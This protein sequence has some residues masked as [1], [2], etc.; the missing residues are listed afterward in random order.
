MTDRVAVR[1]ALISLSNKT[2]LDSL[3][4]GLARHGVELISTGGTAAK[5]RELGHA[6]RDIA[7]VTGFPEIM[8]GRVK[9]LHPKVHGALLGVRDNAEH[10]A[11]ME[12]HGIAPIDL[13]VVNLYPFEATVAAGTD[14]DSIIEN[15]DIGG[16]SMVRSAAKNHAFVT[17]VTDPQDYDAL[18]ADLDANDGA[19]S[20]EL[21]R[22]VAA[23]AFALTAAYD[24]VISQWFAFADQKERFPATWTLSAKL[25]MPLRYGENPHQKAALYLPLGP[26]ARGIAEAEQVQGK[27][28]SY[29]NLNDASAALDLVAEFRNGPPAIVI[30]KHAN[31]CGVARADSLVDA[32]R[33]ALAC[34]GVSAFGGIVAA[35]RPLDGPTAE[36]I[37][38]IFTE[39]VVAPDADADARAIFAKKK[40]LRLLLTGE[41][42]DPA[43]GGQSLAVIAGGLLVQDRDNGRITADDLKCVTK[44]QPTERE[45]ADC[46]FAWTVAKHVKSNAIVYAKD[47][48]TAGIGAGQMN[49]RDSARIAAAKAI[50]AAQTHGW[51]EPRTIGSSVASDA[52]FPFAD[53]LLAAVEAG[54]TAVIQPGGSIRDDEVIAAADEAGLAMLFTGM[55]HFRH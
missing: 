37:A 21:R 50:E 27:E 40:N 35:N 43:R 41:L 39:V 16:P 36:A 18:L 49:R 15:I 25:Q 1:R 51:P 33:A 54:A 26:R 52:F 55:R 10:R 32:W 24:S 5:L 28:L 42:P 2:G 12:E 53:G 46:L 30:V 48:A 11:R 4:A 9:T 45:L 38:A 31:P 7:D 13:V 6:V 3:A 29:N 34:D 20:L 17:V 14:R 22:R 8:D 23:K 47:G 44:R 19:T